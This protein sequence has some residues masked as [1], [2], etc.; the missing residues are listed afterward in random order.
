M[1]TSLKDKTVEEIK[2]VGYFM[3]FCAALI[4]FKALY[5]D[6]LFFID[7]FLC[8]FMGYRACYKPSKTIITWISL[9]YGFDMALS[10]MDGNFSLYGYFIKLAILVWLSSVAYKAYKNYSEETLLPNRIA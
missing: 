6:M 9:Y 7:A 5:S 8:A 3:F 4:S 1:K 2:L 10:F